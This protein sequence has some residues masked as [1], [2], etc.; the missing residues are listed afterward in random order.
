[1]ID[2]TIPTPEGPQVIPAAITVSQTWMDEKFPRKGLRITTSVL[3]GLNNANGQTPVA[4]GITL[5]NV[6]VQIFANGEDPTAAAYRQILHYIQ[7]YGNLENVIPRLK[8]A[9]ICPK[10]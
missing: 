4:P 1:M 9:W 6:I 10:I 3:V 5:N 7:E 2:I 8:H